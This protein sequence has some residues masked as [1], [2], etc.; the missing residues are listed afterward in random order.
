MQKFA[1]R[2]TRKM[3][4]KRILDPR[5]FKDEILLKM[6][7]KEALMYL[8]LW[9]YVESNGCGKASA[10]LIKADILP[11][12]NYTRRYVAETINKLA[13][14]NLIELYVWNEQACFKLRRFE[15]SQN[16]KNP[17]PSK[18][19]GPEGME[20]IERIDIETDNGLSSGKR[21]KKYT[22]KSAAN[23]EA[24]CEADNNNIN[25]NKNINNIYTERT[26]EENESGE[27]FE[28]RKTEAEADEKTQVINSDEE[29]TGDVIN[30]A[31]VKPVDNCIDMSN[32]KSET[33]RKETV[34]D[35]GTNAPDY[36]SSR[37]GSCSGAEWNFR[38]NRQQSRAIEQKSDSSF[39]TDDFFNA[40]LE[41]SRELMAAVARA[42]DG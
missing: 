5:V 11:F 24:S 25:N 10:K 32:V 4:H 2:E 36:G 20:R 26:R 31:E 3:A 37:S 13:E 18:V 15:E 12:L 28:N 14:L 42:G 33:L 9:D 38:R 39:D 8:L 16:F 34:A 23:V 19:R 29:N 17:V 7:Q 35:S 6:T 21:R 22:R 40:A 1:W 41:R 27:G 30:S